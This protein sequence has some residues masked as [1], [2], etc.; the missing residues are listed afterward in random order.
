MLCPFCQHELDLEGMRCPRCGAEYPVSGAGF[1]LRLRTL[2]I[3]GVLM[4]IVSLIMVDCVL[5]DLPGSLAPGASPIR[6]S[7][8]VMREMA[9]RQHHQQDSQNPAP[10]PP[11]R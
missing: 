10:P 2:A 8:E 4:T 5:N 9:M 6:K 7:A 11:M 1:G 3:A